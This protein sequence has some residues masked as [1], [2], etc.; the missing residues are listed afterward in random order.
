MDGGCHVTYIEGLF[1]QVWP[2]FI[3]ASRNVFINRGG[4]LYGVQLISAT[5]LKHEQYRA[6]HGVY[7]KL[8]TAL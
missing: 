4:H 8:N 7:G 6:T 2:P 5:I 1:I 3:E